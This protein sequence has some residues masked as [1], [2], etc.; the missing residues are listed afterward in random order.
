MKRGG[1][2]ERKE[3][4]ER[5]EM[6]GEGDQGNEKRDKEKGVLSKGLAESSKVTA[7]HGNGNRGDDVATG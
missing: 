4:K 2:R 7:I 6:V 1:G 5:R 3:G